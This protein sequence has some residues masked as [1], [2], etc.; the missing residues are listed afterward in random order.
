MF[1]IQR[2]I[3]FFTVHRRCPDINK[4]EVIS[5]LINHV[6]SHHSV[7]SNFHLEPFAG[8]NS[9]T[10]LADGRL[11]FDHQDSL[12][13]SS[14]VLHFTFPYCCLFTGSSTINVAPSPSSLSAYILPPCSVT[15]P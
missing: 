11:V 8:Q 10:D 14:R 12:C 1:I 7:N 6:L 13:F 9:L 4:E 3:E 15:M 5:P 2:V